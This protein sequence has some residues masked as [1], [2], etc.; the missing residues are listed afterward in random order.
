MGS[1]FY[2]DVFDSREI[3]SD[4]LGQFFSEGQTHKAR[5]KSI[6][7]EKYRTELTIRPSDLKV[8]RSQL[9]E[10]FE[11]WNL[12]EKF[13][14]IREDEDFPQ[15]SEAKQQKQLKFAPQ[16][17]AHDK[18]MNVSMAVACEQLNDRQ[19]GDVNIFK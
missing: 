11:G 19:I 1:I 15:I 7:F 13:F 8:A 5:I 17:L 2:L 6:D 16:R 10:M 14:R 9:R 12:L 3:T 4:S 18:Y